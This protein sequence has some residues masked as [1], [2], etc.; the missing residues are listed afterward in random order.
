MLSW[1]MVYMNRVGD[2]ARKS[3]VAMSEIGGRH[4]G[5][6]FLPVL[7]TQYFIGLLSLGSE[8]QSLH[9]YPERG[10]TK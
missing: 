3:G 10:V 5:T 4:A 8:R 9:C 2:A 6:G 7:S 1:E